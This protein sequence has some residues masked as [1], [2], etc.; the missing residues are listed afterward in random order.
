MREV[1]YL[2]RENERLLAR[3]EVLEDRLM[4]SSLS[5]FRAHRPVAMHTPDPEEAYAYFS[6]STGL[7]SER[8]PLSEL[9]R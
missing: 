5:E 4:T 1:K 3:I 7:I 2:R 8:V 6:D 9:D